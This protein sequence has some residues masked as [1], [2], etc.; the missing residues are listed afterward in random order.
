MQECCAPVSPPFAV[1]FASYGL[2]P[3]AR[4][5]ARAPWFSFTPVFEWPFVGLR[6]GAL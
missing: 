5:A 6:R 2:R 4:D 3:G 1:E